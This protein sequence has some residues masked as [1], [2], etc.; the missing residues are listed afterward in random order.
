MHMAAGGA[1]QPCTWLLAVPRNHAHGCWRCF[2]TTHMAAGGASQPCTWLLA[3][4]RNHAHGCWRC[5]ATMHMAAG[6]SR[7]KPTERGL[8]LGRTPAFARL[9]RLRGP[10]GRPAPASPGAAAR[11][12]GWRRFSRRSAGPRQPARTST[13]TD[14]N[15]GLRGYPLRARPDPAAGG[16]RGQFQYYYSG[17]NFGTTTLGALSVLL[18]WGQFQYYYSGG[19]LSTTTLGG[20]LSTTLR[21]SCVATTQNSRN[22][23]AQEPPA[24]WSLCRCPDGGPTADGSPVPQPLNLPPDFPAI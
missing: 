11:R 20:T 1:S 7:A 24:A 23:K 5:F 22:T 16:S 2:A 19:T 10:T 8:R 18:L 17:G 21:S 3:V 14:L 15:A 9:T 12:L 13:R 4:L 6:G